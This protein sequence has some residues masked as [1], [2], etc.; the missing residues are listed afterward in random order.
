LSYQL[1]GSLVIIINS[2]ANFSGSQTPSDRQTLHL[3]L[4]FLLSV[5]FG[6][7]G[8]SVISAPG[9]NIQ[10]VWIFGYQRNKQRKTLDQTRTSVVR[11]EA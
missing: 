3:K 5:C 10:N 8:S 4:Q 2:G 11:G 9:E 1:S 7:R 6:E